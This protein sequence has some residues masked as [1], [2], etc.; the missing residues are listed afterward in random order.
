MS[1]LI[2]RSDVLELLEKHRNEANTLAGEFRAKGDV[3]S[4]VQYVAFAG[5]YKFLIE[6]VED[7]EAVKPH[8]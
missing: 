3:G 6:M 4:W 2:R 8:A 5:I 7:L 1:D